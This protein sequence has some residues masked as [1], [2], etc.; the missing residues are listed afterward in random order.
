[1]DSIKA[2]KSY[3]KL[4]VIK[5]SLTDP[6]EGTVTFETSTGKQL[7]A[8]FWGQTFKINETYLIKF[9]SLDHPSLSW[10][11][12]FSE[13]KNHSK[14]LEKEKN[15]CS[16]LAYGQILSINP[17][18]VDFGDI[19]MENGPSTNDDRVIGEFIY[20]KIDRL[21]VHDVKNCA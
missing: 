13:N 1:M 9:S 3:N 2:D 6:T 17:V 4:K 19:I 14:T 16:Y 7:D 21:D 20:S 18:T 15:E 10:E 8:F 5:V 11:V 12:I